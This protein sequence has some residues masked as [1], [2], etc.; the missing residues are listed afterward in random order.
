MAIR[1]VL[2]LDQVIA[3]V[4]LALCIIIGIVAYIWAKIEYEIEWFKERR[5]RKKREKKENVK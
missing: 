3:L 5:E 4:L 1:V 2:S